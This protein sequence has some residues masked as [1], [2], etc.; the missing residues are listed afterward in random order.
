MFRSS[1][2]SSGAAHRAS[3]ILYGKYK[4]SQLTKTVHAK[5]Y[6]VESS[7]KTGANFCE[8]K[9]IQID[10]RLQVH[11]YVFAERFCIIQSFYV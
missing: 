11:L 7:K 4:V 3:R 10:N 5:S 1:S 8:K 9:I 6:I 2:Q